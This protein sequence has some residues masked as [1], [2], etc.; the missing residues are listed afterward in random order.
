[1]PISLLYTLFNWVTTFNFPISSSISLGWSGKGTNGKGVFRGS[2]II[3]TLKNI[4][5]TILLVLLFV[6]CI[7]PTTIIIHLLGGT[8]FSLVH[9]HCLI[10]IKKCMWF[11]F[12]DNIY[13]LRK[14]SWKT[15]W[16][17]PHD[18]W[19]V[20]VVN[21]WPWW[22]SLIVRESRSLNSWPSKLWGI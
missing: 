15:L 19:M 11:N 4:V 22:Q 13:F 10:S 20:N 3:T 14:V 16:I 18:P 7:I 2:F 17:L 8:F 21:L 9:G 5:Q 1:M 6:L 12:M